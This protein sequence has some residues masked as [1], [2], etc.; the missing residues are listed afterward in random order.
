MSGNSDYIYDDGQEQIGN[1]ADLA[2]G[3]PSSEGE[4]W[5]GRGR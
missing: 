5:G 2:L 1:S 4:M 3:R